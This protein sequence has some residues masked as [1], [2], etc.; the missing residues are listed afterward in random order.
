MHK[1]SSFRTK[2][3]FEKCLI[4]TLIIN[5]HYDN[6][7]PTYLK[8]GYLLSYGKA[9]RFSEIIDVRSPSEFQDD[10]IPGAINL[11]VL[12]DEERSFVGTL[13]KQDSFEGK[14]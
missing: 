8:H 11:P 13:Y 7:L 3:T 9:R 1:N 12:S 14:N 5:F 2:P 4:D 10:H 6:T